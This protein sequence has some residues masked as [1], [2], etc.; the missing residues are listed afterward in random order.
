MIR[1]PFIILA[2]VVAGILAAPVAVM[3]ETV[4]GDRI[5]IIDGDTVALPCA[6]PGRGCAEKVRLLGIDSPETRRPHCERE[7]RLG[8]EAK[9]RLA[10]LLRGHPVEIKRSGKKDRYGRTLAD[11]KID[12]TDVGTTLILDGYA[13]AYRTGADAKLVR[14]KV[15]CGP[16]AE[17]DDVWEGS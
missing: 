10:E 2:A 1:S 7:L 8:L 13:L 6:V 17:L 11:L 14:L 5:R 15:W 4:S 3:A 9:Q 12:D 16:Q